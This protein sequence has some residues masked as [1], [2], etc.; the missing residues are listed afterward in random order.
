MGARAARITREELLT[1]PEFRGL[2]P[3]DHQA[4]R[5]GGARVELERVGNELGWEL[6]TSRFPCGSCP[7]SSSTRKGCRSFT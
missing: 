3:T 2:Q 5:V 7:R 1:P 4:A 6:A